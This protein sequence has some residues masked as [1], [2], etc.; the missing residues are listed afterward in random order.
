MFQNE[1][2]QGTQE[3]Q[4]SQGTQ[5]YIIPDAEEDNTKQEFILDTRFDKVAETEHKK[6]PI[7]LIESSPESMHLRK[8]DW[9]GNFYDFMKVMLPKWEHSNIVKFMKANHITTINKNGERV[10][11]LSICARLTLSSKHF[12]HF[13]MLAQYETD[14]GMP[15]RN[16][17]SLFD[18]PAIP[19][20][21]IEQPFYPD[22]CGKDCYDSLVEYVRSLELSDG[23]HTGIIICK[24]EDSDIRHALQLYIECK[25][26]LI[27]TAA[28]FDG[29]VLNIGRGRMLEQR[30]KYQCADYDEI[31]HYLT[32]VNSASLLIFCGEIYAAPFNPSNPDHLFLTYNE[33]SHSAPELSHELRKI[34]EE[35]IN[36]QKEIKGQIEKQNIYQEQLC[37]RR[38]TRGGGLK[39]KKR[40]VKINIKSK[41]NTK[42]IKNTKLSKR[43]TTRRT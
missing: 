2:T 37:K 39:T 7:E 30:I 10:D 34:T 5:E 43:R 9:K 11:C 28:L 42:N 3:T 8:I 31:R 22:P 18:V 29:Q 35:A 20:R 25:G 33:N 40:K 15:L 24:F 32:S 1:G 16:I 19:G 27:V 23:I 6:P 13:L 36:E 14:D 4:E 17:T 26:R 21:C 12:E 41:K 38:K